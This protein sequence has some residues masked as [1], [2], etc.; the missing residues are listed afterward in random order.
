MTSPTTVSL[1]SWSYEDGYQEGECHWDEQCNG[2]QCFIDREYEGQSGVVGTCRVSCDM[3]KTD[4]I[5][6]QFNPDC[7]MGYE[8]FEGQCKRPNGTICDA[9]EECASN[10]CG[11]YSRCRGKNEIN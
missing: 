10:V 4:P 6:K 9:D 8:C 11:E 7:A 2:Y 5:G 3:T 1:K